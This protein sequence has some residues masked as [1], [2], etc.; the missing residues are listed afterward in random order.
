MLH[1]L[2]FASCLGIVFVRQRTPRAVNFTLKLM[3][4]HFC[5]YACRRFFC[6]SSAA[7]RIV[8]ARSH[9]VP[10]SARLPFMK[11]TSR[12][13]QLTVTRRTHAQVFWS[14]IVLESAEITNHRLPPC[15]KCITRPVA[16][17]SLGGS[18]DPLISKSSQ[19]S[20]Q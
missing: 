4:L 18:E 16:R 10:L 14:N 7:L 9:N 13:L 8:C 11:V 5:C 19:I 12:A 17:G 20:W 2:F 6:K 3:L 15:C 1:C